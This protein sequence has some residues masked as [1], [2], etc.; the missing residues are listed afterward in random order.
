MVGTKNGFALS[1]Y[2]RV[3]DIVF[4]LAANGYAGEASL[5]AAGMEA[6]IVPLADVK[7]LVLSFRRRAVRHGKVQPGRIDRFLAEVS[8]VFD[9]LAA[10]QMDNGPTQT[11]AVQYGWPKD[12]MTEFE[13]PFDLPDSFEGVWDAFFEKWS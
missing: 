9:Q 8:F 5:L 12:E 7:F 6:E 3:G 1:T 11:E 4:A 2:E 13:D 10:F